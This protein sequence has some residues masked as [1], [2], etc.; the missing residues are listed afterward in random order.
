M[1]TKLKVNQQNI[2]FFGLALIA[3]GLPLGTFF[4]SV[5]EMILV[6]S[7]LADKNVLN[8]FRNFFRSKIALTISSLFLLHIIGLICTTDFAYAY[9]DLRVKFPLLILPLIVSTTEGLDIKRFRFLLMVFILAVITS[10]CLSMY[11]YFTFNFHDIREICIYVSHIRLSLFICLAIFILFYFV[12]LVKD[13]NKIQKFIFVVAVLWLVIFLYILES[14]TGLTIFVITGLLLIIIQVFLAKKIFYKIG[15]IALAAGFFLSVFLYIGSIVR[16]YFSYTP[17]KDIKL[18]KLTAHANPY[19]HDTVSNEM[20]NGYY[21][22]RYICEKE[23]EDA[24]NKRS[25]LKYFGNNNKEEYLK[26]PLIRFLTSKGLHKDADGVNK[27]S[28]AEIKS[29]EDGAVN[30]N[31]QNQYSLRTRIYETIW[32]LDKYRKTGDPNGHSVMQRLEYWKASWLIIKEHWLFGVGTGDMNIAFAS[33]YDKMNSPLEKQWRLRSH[34]QFLSITV[35]FGVFGLLWFLFVLAYP[36][37]LKRVRKDFYYFVFF[38][39]F[40]LS[41]T[42]ED[43][44][45]SQAGLTFY[46]FFSVLFLLGRKEEIN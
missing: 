38:I 1:N 3:I 27:L 7:W 35:G 10:T 12:F 44:I 33:Q 36:F 14:V 15:F 26:Y 9:K 2:Y 34:N 4:M 32:E 30:V 24:W 45:E 40:L 37:T 13:F 20:E 18:E 39:I 19:S 8:K 25:T 43:T 28:D 6:A 21:V 11:N 5:G 16:Q 41:M 31:C 29:I 17:E 42:N 23:L 22:W 46:V